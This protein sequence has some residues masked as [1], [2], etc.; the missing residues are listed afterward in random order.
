MQ[1]FDVVCATTA[2]VGWMARVPGLDFS[3]V[4]VDECAQGTAAETLLPVTVVGEAATV[5]LIGDAQQLGPAVISD[6][7][8]YHGL[9]RPFFEAYAPQ[10]K[11]PPVLSTTL[12]RCYRCHPAI[13]GIFNRL[14]YGG[15]LEPGRRA[16]SFAPVRCAFRPPR[17]PPDAR[18]LFVDVKPLAAAAGGGFGGD[19]GAAVG[20]SAMGANATYDNPDEADAVVAAGVSLLRDNRR[21]DGG[22]F[23]GSIGVIAG[24]R[25][26]VLTINA[27]L[28][29]AP[30]ISAAERAAILVGTVDQYQGQE[31]PVVLLS[32]VRATRDT[33]LAGSSAPAGLV[34]DAR[35]TNV[36]LSRAASLLV[37]FGSRDGLLRQPPSEP[38]RAIVESLHKGG[39]IVQPS[40][41]RQQ[42]LA[43]APAAGGAQVA[44][45]AAAADFGDD[46]W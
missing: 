33:L 34:G 37:V 15:F 46:D 8:Q 7:A 13:L 41:V 28:R 26:Q 35:K 9:G 31:R 39:G 21:D 17:A 22:S 18:V 2:H 3:Y 11:A 14:F 44:A 36:A 43:A 29:A 24:F 42:K 6:V 4:F 16:D 38:W 27:R 30:G 19:D 5:V 45:A 12:K 40:A 32:M 25:H 1:Q 23:A 20:V 10:L